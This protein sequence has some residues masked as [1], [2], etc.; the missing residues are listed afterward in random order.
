MPLTL[1]EVADDPGGGL[2]LPEGYQFENFWLGRDGGRRDG[3]RL[4]IAHNERRDEVARMELDETETR[5]ALRCST[6]SLPQD[7]PPLLEIQFIDV[8]DQ[9]RLQGIGTDLVRHVE[10]ENPEFQLLALSEGSE[11]FWQSLGWDRILP[12]ER[13]RRELFVCPLRH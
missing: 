5:E 4:F 6:Y 8:R 9:F 2:G 10:Q 13:R 11:G 12:D 1:T 7:G 3:Y